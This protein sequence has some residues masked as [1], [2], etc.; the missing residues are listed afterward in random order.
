MRSLFYVTF[1][2]LSIEWRPH[3]GSNWVR[4]LGLSLFT[5][6]CL[7]FLDHNLSLYWFT[8]CLIQ[9]RVAV[10]HMRAFF[11]LANN[12]SG[13]KIV[14]EREIDLLVSISL[15]LR[16]NSN[17]IHHWLYHNERSRSFFYNSFDFIQQGF[18]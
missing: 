4:R 1:L 11:D 15:K 6:G 7:V 3:K 17:S 9:L 2:F 10:A 13:S 16:N 12:L 14:L 18:S 5:F 8:F